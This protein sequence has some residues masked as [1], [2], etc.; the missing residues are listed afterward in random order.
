MQ[1]VMLSRCL[2]G[3]PARYDGSVYFHEHAVLRRWL[4]EGRIV[5][6][7]PE[8]AGGLPVPRPAAEI[9]S[10]LSPLSL[11]NGQTSARVVMRLDRTSRWLL[12]TARSRSSRWRGKKVSALPC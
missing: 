6:V 12:L 8:M 11:P 9:N 5:S 3:E 10:A 2:L 4:A 7:C 1:R